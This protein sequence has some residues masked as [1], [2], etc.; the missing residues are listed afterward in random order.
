LIVSGDEFSQLKY[1]VGVKTN[2]RINFLSHETLDRLYVMVFPNG[3]MTIPRGAEY[4]N[5]GPFLEVKDFDQ[6]LNASQFDS[7]KHLRHSLGWGK[8]SI[9][10]KQVLNFGQVGS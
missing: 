5:F 9:P 1:Q 2:I 3:N 8:E 7:A 4:Q 6:V 10:M